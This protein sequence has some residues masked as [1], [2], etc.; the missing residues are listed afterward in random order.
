MVLRCVN[1]LID[2]D[3]KIKKDKDLNLSLTLRRIKMTKTIIEEVDRVEGLLAIDDSELDECDY[4]AIDIQFSERLQGIIDK[5]TK[6]KED[7]IANDYEEDN[8]LDYIYYNDK[9]TYKETIHDMIVMQR[10]FKKYSVGDK[11]K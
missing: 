11:N 1:N 7:A 6:L 4:M 2:N 3:M 8:V 9:E 10:L 5:L